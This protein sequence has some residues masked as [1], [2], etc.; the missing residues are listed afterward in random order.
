MGK[1]VSLSEKMLGKLGWNGRGG[2]ILLVL[3]LEC[4][5][6]SAYLLVSFALH[7]IYLP[8]G[9]C[10]DL[11]TCYSCLALGDLVNHIRTVIRSLES[12]RL[13]K[14]RESIAMV[15]GRDVKS[16]EEEGVCRAAVETMAENF[17]D[18]F[19][20]PLFWCLAGG[21]LANLLGLYPVKTALSFMLFFKVASTLDSMV[22][23]KSPKYEQFGRAGARLDDFM[24][25]IPARLSLAVLFAGAFFTGLHPLQGLRV[26]LRDRLKH[27]SPNSAHA[28][29]F[30]AGALNSRLGGPTTYSEGL[31][32]KPWLGDGDIDPGPKHV[33]RTA[34]LVKCSAWIAVV[35]VLSIL[36]YS[37]I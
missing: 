3:I 8:L 5:S 16:L 36:F 20:S 7:H 27:E 24:N 13:D 1:G 30:A 15:V 37:G 32:D 2:G 28:E 22:G 4:S 6:V 23:Y 26:A 12:G 14:A 35:V 25:F 17:V 34:L 31:K 19:L 33:R 9:L 18:G 10:F 29:S 11:Y 21:I